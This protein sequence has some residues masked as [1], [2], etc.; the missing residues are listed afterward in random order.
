MAA[1]G[2]K[3]TLVFAGDDSKLSR[4]LAKVG[5]ETSSLTNTIGA[6]GTGFA[7]FGAAAGLGAAAV[8]AALPV[9]GSLALGFGVVKLAMASGNKEWKAFQK[10]L[11]AVNKPMERLRDTAANSLFP[12]LTKGL[13]DSIGL[14]PIFESAIG[15]TGKIMGD[16]ASRLGDLFKTQK[17][18]N[19]LDGF[20]RATEPVTRAIGDLLVG[21]TGKLVEFGSKMA[22]AGEGFATFI[23]DAQSGLEGFLDALEPHAGDFKSIFESLGKIVR[24]VL[25]LIGQFAGE[26]SENLA[27]ILE[28]VASFIARNKDA[29]SAWI[30]FLADAATHIGALKIGLSVAGWLG[31]AGKAIADIGLKA[32]GAGEKVSGFGGKLGGLKGAGGAAGVA[33]ALLGVADAIDKINVN[34]A[35]GAEKLDGIAVNLHQFMETSKKLLTGGIGFNQIIDQAR[36]AARGIQN[37]FN[38][39][40]LTPIT[41]E[42]NG[43]PAKDTLDRFISEI[44]TTVPEVNINGNTTGAGFALREI[45]R[46][47]DAGKGE[48]IIDGQ[49]VP[50]QDALQRVISIINAANGVVNIDGDNHAAGD[51]LA[52]IL[53]QVNAARPRITIDG[54]PDPA[55]GKVTQTVQLA[56]GSK[57]TITVDGN[58]D[59][60]T[61]KINGTVRFANGSRGTVTIDG[62]QQPANGKINATVTY[63]NGRTATIQ[64]SA[65]TGGAQGVIDGFINRNDG[66]RIRIFT[67]VLGSGG[68]ASAGRLATGGPVQGPGTGTSDT[69]GLFALSNGEYVLTARQVENAGGF[70]AVARLAEA[71]DRGHAAGMARGGAVRPAQGALR[72]P[73]TG[74]GA[75]ATVT[76]AGNTT[77]ALA[78]VIMHMIRLGKIQI[79]A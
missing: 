1:G 49:P 27:P 3:V 60:A 24:D 47:I 29:I 55:T 7:L 16:T 77:D 66:R 19:D 58:P 35:G 39:V 73:V 52:K 20:L 4:T 6:A 57:G 12:G 50:A 61:G 65:S 37:A 53:E 78:T 34:S 68:I 54:N 38:G 9:L 32:F 63:A 79:A 41:L 31:G 14:F 59:P 75:G 76:F 46:E 33:V 30:P 15:R 26:M 36:A 42:A 74:N 28:N 22:P 40:K 62:N 8:G 43:R 18:K 25:P 45:V 48:I 44:N 13:K 17:F 71:L 2:P 21:M 64:V 10:Q 72:R 5:A 69:A 51:S 56:N 11:D 67:S 70:A 23:R